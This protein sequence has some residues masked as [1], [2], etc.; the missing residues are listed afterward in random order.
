MISTERR[1]A[2]SKRLAPRRAAST[3]PRKNQNSNSLE[4]ST[5]RFNES[6]P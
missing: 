2:R 5:G 3:N 1:P 6:W 4:C